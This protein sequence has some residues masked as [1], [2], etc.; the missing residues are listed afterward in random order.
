MIIEPEKTEVISNITTNRKRA[1]SINAE[2][3]AHIMTTLTNLYG[4]QQT[5]VIRE[6]V[7]NAV[8]S[9]IASGQTKH[10]E[11]S[12]PDRYSNM[13]VVEDFGVGM[14]ATELEKYYGEYGASSKRDTNT[15]IGAFGLGAKSPLSI[16][17]QF[18]VRSVKDG[19]LA[20]ALIQ[21]APDGLNTI[22]IITEMDTDL[23][24]GV[25]VSIPIDADGI[26]AF[27]EKAER[28]FLF[29]ESSM[30]LVNGSE[31]ESIYTSVSKVSDP[32]DPDFVAYVG[33]E[34]GESVVVMGGIPYALN[35]TQMR[36]SMRRLG[37][38]WTYSFLE[39]HK[40]FPVAIG[41]VD[42]TPQREGLRF[43]ERTEAV[44]DRL[45]GSLYA[46]L[47]HSAQ[48]EIDAADDRREVYALLNRW[49][50]SLDINKDKFTW[51][52]EKIVQ[53]VQLAN[54]VAMVTY[55]SSYSKNSYST[56]YGI[57]LDRESDVLVLVGRGIDRYKGA[58]GYIND[59][60]KMI[61]SV[62]GEKNFLFVDEVAGELDI[63]WFTDNSRFTFKD[64]EEFIAE[65]KAYRKSQKPP[66]EPKGPREYT[67]V[68]YPVFDVDANTLTHV[69]AKAIPAG[70]FLV[71]PHEGYYASR[72]ERIFGSGKT[73]NQLRWNEREETVKLLAE[74]LPQVK[75]LVYL[76][77][78]RKLESLEK[79]A[80]QTFTDVWTLVGQVDAEVNSLVED[81]TLHLYRFIKSREESF[82]FHLAKQDG[83]LDPE[84]TRLQAP[85]GQEDKVARLEKVGRVAKWFPNH[86]SPSISYVH[87]E[88]PEWFNFNERD[89]R[90]KYVLLG[91]GMYGYHDASSDIMTHAVAYINA[92]Y[93][94][95]L[96]KG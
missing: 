35:N 42:L 45:I 88:A 3:L 83:L 50:K 16:A 40:I 57:A 59:Y 93:T 17:D 74:V 79:R 43:T 21:K 65:V 44:V 77:P 34:N 2:G 94:S 6:V 89:L 82:W 86:A 51:R 76:A 41:D 46:G 75:H 63:E 54:P 73:Y 31:P 67:K 5:A 23:P 85:K 60:C 38:S 84:I 91:N 11:V 96:V 19:R 52:G 7:A 64:V 22:D 15:Q 26:E 27:N 30:L 24:N 4:D 49:S 53:R 13:F 56:N 69:E 66:K 81:P 25:K 20:S 87:D 72:F 62:Y 58:A 14:T 68:T 8:D 10:I 29:S 70:A 48:A 55:T 37:L 80:K 32:N 39:M 90:S 36:D 71:T 61:D 9:H 1:M 92:V 33:E 12:L 28:F 78:N 47:S 18:T 95:T